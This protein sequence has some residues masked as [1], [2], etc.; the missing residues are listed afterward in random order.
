MLDSSCL[1]DILQ[2]FLWP[3]HQLA[4]ELPANVRHFLQD[5]AH[6]GDTGEK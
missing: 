5:E 2:I 4:A 1:P 3:R 6:H